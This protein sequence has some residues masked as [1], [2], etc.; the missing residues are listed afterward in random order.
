[1]LFL[2]APSVFFGSTSDK[3]FV[4]P[5][6]T[7][8]SDVVS[9]HGFSV[10]AFSLAWLLQGVLLELITADTLRGTETAKGSEMF[11]ARRWCRGEDSSGKKLPGKEGRDELLWAEPEYSILRF[12]G[13]VGL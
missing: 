1:M 7:F 9:L 13:D 12:F 11:T 6:P 3:L 10:A 5:S 4:F 8:C 2:S